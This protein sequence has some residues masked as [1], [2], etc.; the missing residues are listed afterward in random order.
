MQRIVCPHCG[1]EF[2]MPNV[3]RCP[4]CNKDL[5]DMTDEYAKKHIKKCAYYLNPY[6]YSDRKRGR[7]RG[8]YRLKRFSRMLKKLK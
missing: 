1:H 3:L 8:A 6:R 2:D 4:Y 7:P 5:S